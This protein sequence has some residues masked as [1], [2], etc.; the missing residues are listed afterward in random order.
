MWL[1]AVVSSGPRERVDCRAARRQPF[2]VETVEGIQSGGWESAFTA[3]HL[4]LSPPEVRVHQGLCWSGLHALSQREAAALFFM[5]LGRRWGIN[6]SDTC[7]HSGCNFILAQGNKWRDLQ[8]LLKMS[9]WW[10]P[11]SKM[12]VL[13]VLM[14]RSTTEQRFYERFEFTLHKDAPA[15]AEACRPFSLLK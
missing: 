10:L 13:K 7:F 1:V 12:N 6:S 5:M 3:L 11:F 4:P 2:S 9:W 15:H 14:S 8:G